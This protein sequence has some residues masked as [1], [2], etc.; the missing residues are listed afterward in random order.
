MKLYHFTLIFAA[1]AAL[2]LGTVGLQVGEQ[3]YASADNGFYDEAL[4][5]ACDAAAGVLKECGERST[6]A[7]RDKAV[8]IFFD[9]LAASLAISGNVPAVLSLEMYVPVILVTEADGFYV[10]ASQSDGTGLK[11]HTYRFWSEKH[12]YSYADSERVYIFDSDDSLLSVSIDEDGQPMSVR[13]GFGDAALPD[14]I[15][16]I[17]QETIVDMLEQQLRISCSEHNRVASELGIEY[18]FTIPE[19]D[20]GIYLRTAAGTG[21]AAFFQ[22]YPIRQSSD[23][24]YSGYSFAGAGVTPKE[25]F[26]INI[27]GEGYSSPQYSHIA[28][29]PYLS[30]WSVM[31]TTGKECALAGARECPECRRKHD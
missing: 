13:L 23:E 8:R 10:Y 16:E 7:A 11:G 31:Y 14:N 30:D 2:M 27:E 15:E 21:F 19:T 6:T 29:C 12:R 5:R 22:G 20:G 3:Y 18:D 26:F 28:G 24:V 9:S 4:D 1:V 17:R 25:M